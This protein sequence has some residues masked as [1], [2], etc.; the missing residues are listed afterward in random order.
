MSL[1]ESFSI[2]LPPPN[3]TG[4]LHMG[5]AFNQTIMDGLTRYYRM[6]GRNTCWIPGADHAGIATQIVVERQLAEQGISR[7]DLGREAF[8]E[9][10]WQ[11]KNVSGGTITELDL[12][13]EGRLAPVNRERGL[14]KA[15]IICALVTTP[16]P[17]HPEGM[18]RIV[19]SGDPT[20]GLGAVA[21]PECRRIIA[22][23][24]LAEQMQVPVEW[25][26]LSSGARIS[27]DSGTENMD[28]VGAALRRIIEFTQAGG[29]I[30][31]VVAGINVGAQPYWN[32]EA[33]ML[34]HTKGILVM[35][36]DSAMVLTGKQSLDFSGGVSA[37]DNFGIGGYD[38]VMGPNGQAQYWA[39]NLGAAME[40]QMHPQVFVG[41]HLALNNARNYREFAGGLYVRYAFQPYNGL[42]VFPV[43]PLRSPY[44]N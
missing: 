23:L 31:I 43:N 33:T 8:L 29:E 10:V 13:A 41:G 7:H 22:A 38:R 18:T 35:T 6:K 39:P 27:M 14:N 37:E 30:N 17:L 16:T 15:G 1:T 19:L 5:H 9:K 21:E 26:T 12:D 28:W 42:Q 32:A 11:W 20:R 34:M 36:P 25:F 24:D 3:V 2:Q 40:Y 4:T 44:G